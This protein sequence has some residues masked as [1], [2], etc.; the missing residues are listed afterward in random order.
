MAKLWIA[1]VG[2]ILVL[3]ALAALAPVPALAQSCAQDVSG[4][5]GQQA[6]S[7]DHWAYD[8][9]AE[10]AEKGIVEGYPD[11]SFRGDRAMTRFEIAMIILR[12][13]RDMI[14]GEL[15]DEYL[16]RPMALDMD[17]DGKKDTYVTKVGG[18]WF[19]VVDVDA[20]GRVDYVWN[21]TNGDG[22]PSRASCEDSTATAG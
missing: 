16:S 20:D 2:T 1:N 3:T 15:L 10:F 9:I 4:G 19:G 18:R 11:G 13:S 21:D 22:Q 8:A 7:K 12:P 17:K 6:P 5:E 14:E